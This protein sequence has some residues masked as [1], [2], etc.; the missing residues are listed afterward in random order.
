MDERL[1]ELFKYFK[2]VKDYIMDDTNNN[3][4]TGC[5]DKVR[6][7]IFEYI[8]NEFLMFEINLDRYESNQKAKKR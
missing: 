5:D 2:G 4:L 3:L 6:A 1:L 8:L 7:L